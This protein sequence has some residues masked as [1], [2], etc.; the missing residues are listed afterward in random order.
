MPAHRP[1]RGSQSMKVSRFSPILALGLSLLVGAAC[2]QERE[3]SFDTG[4]EDAYLIFGV[5]ET[6][7]VGV[8]FWCTIGMGEIRIFIPEAGEKLPV[9]QTVKIDLETGGK[10]F[11][12]SGETAVNEEAG[13]TSID[14]RIEA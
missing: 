9:G 4:E 2:A 14:A 1:C 12:I 11:T 8:S 3:W 13:S 6:D 10:R 7:D 5:P